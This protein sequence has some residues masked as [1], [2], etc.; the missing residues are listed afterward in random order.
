MKKFLLAASSLLLLGGCVSQDQADAK[1]AKGCE[2]GANALIKPAMLKEIKST[3]FSFEENVE[4]QHRRV[5]LNTITKDGWLET[6]KQYSCLF[7]Q[8]WGFFKSSHAGILVQIK[9]PDG[10]IVGKED[11]HILGEVDDYLKL[12]DTVQDAMKQE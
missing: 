5:T 10:K 2:A 1:L 4:G 3:N 9:M 7:A 6:D 8:Q 11:G 12:S